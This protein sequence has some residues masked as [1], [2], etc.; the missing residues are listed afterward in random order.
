MAFRAHCSA[1]NRHRHREPEN[2]SR[3][4]RE[5]NRLMSMLPQ[6][7]GVKKQKP[8]GGSRSPVNEERR[9]CRQ[10]F[11]RA[12]YAMPDQVMIEERLCASSFMNRCMRVTTSSE[13]GTI[14]SRISA[15]A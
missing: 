5:S 11:V 12:L 9:A 4:P 6:K 2:G 14:P 3:L 13:S 7:E 8:A 10:N 1:T 15:F